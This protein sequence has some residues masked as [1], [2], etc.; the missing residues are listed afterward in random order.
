[1]LL[2]ILEQ[3]PAIAG[4]LLLLSAC[5]F[6]PPQ[7]PYAGG[8]PADSRAPVRPVT[9]TGVIGAYQSQRPVA[10]RDWREQNERVAP[11]RRP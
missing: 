10:P 5:S 7:A 9:D 11:Q 6:S 3:A 8:D 2:K 1:M 4:A